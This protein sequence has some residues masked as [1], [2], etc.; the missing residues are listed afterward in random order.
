MEIKTQTG[1]KEE[2]APNV[3]LALTPDNS[4]YAEN[5]SPTP[6]ESSSVPEKRQW[7]CHK[8][9]LKSN[10][11]YFKSILSSQFQ[12]AEASIVFLPRGMF[13]VSVLDGLLCYMYTQSLP[14]EDSQALQS[15]YLA[16]DYLGMHPL[17]EAVERLFLQLTHG[18]VC[19]C[20]SCR[21]QVPSLLAFTGQHA[22]HHALSEMT[23]A[24]LK[25]L[26]SD[27]EKAI[28]TFWCS[29][30]TVDLIETTPSLHDY[31]TKELKNHVH[32][33]NAIESLTGCFGAET[34][35]LD[36]RL[37]HTVAEVKTAAADLVANDFLFYCT[38]YPKLLSCVDG[39]TYSFDF[40][41]YLMAT[42]LS[43]DHMHERNVC[44]L[45][46]GIVKHLMCRDSVQRNPQ[47]KAMLQSAKDAT[48]AYIGTHLLTLK[49]LNLINKD[50]IELLAQ[51]LSLPKHALMA[52]PEPTPKPHERKKPTGTRHLPYWHTPKWI[53][54]HLVSLF[55]SRQFKVGQRVELV[56]RPIRTTG[57]IAYAGRVAIDKK[58]VEYRL[59]IL[60][61]RGV[62]NCDGSIDGER[63]FTTNPNRGVFVKSS[64][65]IIL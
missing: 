46:K 62:G 15:L 25:L 38:T 39:I 17:V 31:L 43:R 58:K 44:L 4:V 61:D 48:I 53:K 26:V 60:L 23:Q 14:A 28:P 5:Q 8:D 3:I 57:T 56:H 1:W 50:L 51:D 55:F 30:V 65:V 9:V 47:A 19:Y 2:I 27:P 29:P 54:T 20:E 52:E 22:E 41:H 33:H 37:L 16:G 11:N 12:E 6:S 40:L 63:Y 42:V 13:S 45:Y 10:S 24:L 49:K 32:K 7:S 34:H 35:S 64:D 18:M 36:P 21:V 59:G